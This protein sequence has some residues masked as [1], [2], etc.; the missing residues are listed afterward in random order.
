M[1]GF[2]SLAIAAEETVVKPTVE[3]V[4][5]FKNG[6][7]VVRATFPVTGTG[8][9]RWDK[10]PRAI[11]GSFWIE[12]D[13]E[14]V[15]QT[16][17][18][19]VE[20]VDESDSPSGMMQQDLAGKEVAVT[21]RKTDSAQPPVITGKV[22]EV[23]MR[24][25]NRTW[26]ADYSTLKDSGSTY[27]WG[28]RSPT[29]I[30]AP[31]RAMAGSTG[32]FLVLSDVSG[33]RRYIDM[34]GVA[35]VEAKGPFGSVKRK[36]EK[37]VMLF[38]V[39]K[40]PAN[41]GVVR[42]SWLTKGLAWM[43]A[44]QVDLSNPSKLR[45]RQ[46]AVVKN[47]SD[48]L[49]DTEIQLISGFPNVRFGAVDSPLWQG[50]TMAAFFQQLNQSSYSQNSQ[51]RSAVTQNAISF[52]GGPANGSSS[53]PDS[54]EKGSGSN[55]I[56]YESIGRHTLKAGDSLSV[57]IATATSA[58]ERVV[59]WVVTDERDIYG[60]YRRRDETVRDDM[61]WDAVRFVNPFK[62]P[63]TTA[64]ALVT[65]GGKF[66]GQS[67]SDWVNPGQR[68]CLRITRA[69]SVQTEA[70]EIEEEG[71][72]ESL[73]IA[74][75][76]YRRTVVKGRLMVRNFRGKEATM[77]IRVEFSGKLIE[78]EGKPDSKLRAE[79]VYSVN[80]RRQLDWTI[81][82]AAGQEKE[83]TYRYEVLVRD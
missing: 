50:T 20:E 48:D 67:Q 24:M 53:M 15:V 33:N 76:R 66:R 26:D 8:N 62:F 55:D 44:Y 43:P 16:T 28:Y 82:L 60:C 14:V 75:S 45:I 2:A 52:N 12:S 41:G 59:E 70:G 9:Y 71:Q 3:S 31:P 73:N 29:L 38:D 51:L 72:R 34:A 22:W 83:L 46:N 57:D 77:A 74:G 42:V 80:P 79:G 1:S 23:P 81:P 40:T 69:L 19:M 21:L 35:A 37:P 17:T 56:H 64:A 54:P 25:P 7:A 11:H 78:A 4:G 63:M 65:E 32:N 39:R 47:E 10:V 49:A 18:R 27:Y 68:A 36:A 5:L 6:L 61:P 30:E 58:Y 13:G